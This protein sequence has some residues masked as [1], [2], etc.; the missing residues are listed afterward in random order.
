MGKGSEGLVKLKIKQVGTSFD[1]F[2]DDEPIKLDHLMGVNLEMSPTDGNVLTLTYRVCDVD[3][4]V[5]GIEKEVGF[6]G[7]RE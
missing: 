4:E 1:A 2:L 7:E 6:F 5:D 3:V